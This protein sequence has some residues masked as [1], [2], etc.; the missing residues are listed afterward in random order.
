MSAIDTYLNYIASKVY[1]RDVRT[2]IVNAIRQCYNDVNNPTLLT[3]G[4]DTIIQNY[5]NN[6]RIGNAMLTATDFLTEPTRNLFD[7]G[8]VDTGRINTSTGVVDSTATGYR[9]S[10]L[11]P[12]T[13]DKI[14]KFVN[15]D[16]RVLFDSNSQYSSNI[17][18]ADTWTATL[19]GYIKVSCTTANMKLCAVYE[20]YREYPYIP[21]RT[22][23][24]IIARRVADAILAKIDGSLEETK[25][26]FDKS[27]VVYGNYID[28]NTGKLVY[29]TN[30]VTS[31]FIPVTAGTTYYITNR[32]YGCLYDSNKERVGNIGSSTFTPTVDGY[33]RVSCTLSNIDKIQVEIGNKATEYRP[34]YGMKDYYLR[35]A[36]NPMI[37]ATSTDIGKALKAKTV[38]DGK[39]TEWKFEDI[40]VDPEM[41]EQAISDWLDEHPEATT[42]VQDGSITEEKFSSKLKV[43]TSINLNGLT[44]SENIVLPVAKSYVEAITYLSP[45]Y[46]VTCRDYTNTPHTN[47]IAIY[48]SSY[49]LVSYVYTNSAYG[50]SNNIFNDGTRIYVD[51]DSGYH[52]SFDTSLSDDDVVLN[53]NIRNMAF[54]DNNFY[55]ITINANDVTVSV[56]ESDLTT[57]VSSFSVATARQ[58]LQSSSIIDGILIIPTAK[59]L[60]K[61][62]D[63]VNQALI[64]EIPYYDTKEIE[65]FFK[66][67]DGTIKCCGHFYGLDG[68]FNIGSFNNGINEAK[69]QYH[70]IDGAVGNYR[71]VQNS[72]RYGFY[73]I[74]N[75]TSMGLPIDTGD[76]L[77]FQ[78]VCL[79]A[80]NVDNAIYSYYNV[81]W[82]LIGLA[83]PI[84][85]SVAVGSYTVAFEVTTC[86]HFI[87]RSG[88]IIIT[89]ATT[90]I[91]VDLSDIYEKLGLSDAR[92]FSF[93]L[94]GVTAGK[95]MIHSDAE[96]YAT[97][98]VV[99]KTKITFYT[100]NITQN[101]T[102]NINAKFSFYEQLL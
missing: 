81:N 48:N 58:T 19:T 54:W 44:Y 16:R 59:G 78:N 30:Y 87:V 99:E 77:V 2:A 15:T 72:G 96:L 27:T 33:A 88:V 94:T 14:Y 11:I 24:D 9:T 74:T 49:A 73:E 85:Q 66:D 62:I 29:A 92:S 4:I 90:T 25:N 52:V 37:T 1:A 61:F 22:P 64:A 34:H 40:T 5:I 56:L 51:F 7:F 32:A 50:I 100:R 8:T 26:L 53:T 43:L 97:A 39:V 28:G 45:Y 13:Q 20:D 69:M 93:Y 42:T 101:S 86:G 80:S 65:S 38:T 75:G 17:S 102:S 98:V 41:V 3:D 23:V 57:V 84:T 46:Y 83:Y 76:L 67:A 6:G 70:S 12:V 68:M 79:M 82:K 47:Y 89:N 35:D 36:V 71:I 60:F 21:G 95:N 10:K 91:N 18:S 31:D 63:V 55:G